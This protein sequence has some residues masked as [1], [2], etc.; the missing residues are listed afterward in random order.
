MSAPRLALALALAAAL[1]AAGGVGGYLLY[2]RSQERA[3]A[4]VRTEFILPDL[5]GRP[6][7]VSQWDGKVLVL[8]FWAT[9]CPPCVREV[10]LLVE[11]QRELADSGLQIVGIAVDRLED[12]R[13]FAEK[14]GIN[15]PLLYGVQEAMEVGLHYGNDAGT[16]PFTVVIDRRGIIRHV[17]R[18]E[19]ERPALE[20]AIRPLL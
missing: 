14:M 9:W 7:N 20:A 13:A 1:G 6:Q 2:E 4:L 11:L 12:V 19:L 15:Y 5:Q 18:T 3:A 10:P 8:N 16:L 17:F